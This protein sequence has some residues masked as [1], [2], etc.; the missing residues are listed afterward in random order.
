MYI[1]T[2]QV[3]RVKVDLYEI[4][5]ESEKIIVNTNYWYGYKNKTTSN[6]KVKHTL[7]CLLTS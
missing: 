4:Q 7:K 6:T 2:Q 5:K 1:A 3:I